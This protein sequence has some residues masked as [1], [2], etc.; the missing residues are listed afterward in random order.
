MATAPE[1]SSQIDSPRAWRVAIAAATVVGVSFGTIYTFGAFFEAMADEFDAG[2]GS[3]SIVFGITVF[4]FFGTGA[5]SGFLA[6]RWGARPLVLVGGGL[7]SCGL[8]ATSQVDALWQGYLTYGVG[9]GLGGGLFL[10][11]LFA[12]AAAW[13]DR[14]RAIAQGVV[15]TGSGLGTLILLPVAERIIDG[16]GWRDAYVALAAI[17]AVVFVVCGALIERPPV[18]PPVAAGRH[19]RGVLQTQSFRRLAAAVIMQSASMISAFAF[20]VPFATD[21]GVSSSTAAWLVGIIGAS[22]IVGRLTLTGFSGRLGPVRTLQ[23]SFLAQP[24]AFLIW[25]LADGNLVLLGVFVVVLGVSYGGFVALV[26]MVTAHLF[27]IEGIGSVMGWV[28]LAAGTGSLVY[29]PI[30]GFL[31]DATDTATVP[32]LAVLAASTTGA[33]L[34]LRLSPHPVNHARPEVTPAIP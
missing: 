25:L 16:R 17:T 34:L 21:D 18:A 24:A 7:F 19:L 30:V 32:I 1:P 6:D 26:G 9:A 13:F 28:Y 14:Y 22:S 3:T 2:L 33:L 31:A 23:L 11:P 5:A 12:M 27:G 4:L 15:A 8:L 29:P 20:I 10:S